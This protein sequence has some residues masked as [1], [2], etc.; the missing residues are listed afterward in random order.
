MRKQLSDEQLDSLL[1]QLVDEASASDETL[2]EIADSPA[3]W[4]SVQREIRRSDDVVV[5]PWPPIA[6]YL[7]WFFVTVP[8]AAAVIIA[9]IFMIGTWNNRS[10]NSLTSNQPP[11]ETNVAPS[12]TNAIPLRQ[13]APATVSSSNSVPTQRERS[14]AIP[15]VTK[16]KRSI[17]KNLMASRVKTRE[18]IKTDFISLTYAQQ[19]SSGQVLRVKVPSAMMVDLGV[20]PTVEK[21]TS[22][23]EAE[24]L[25]GDDGMTHAIRFI[26][27][28]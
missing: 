8:A 28:R 14:N 2:D 12:T 4:W 7:R 5:S 25:V 21:P 6:R 18:E 22:L 23:V 16:V 13:E 15:A 24:V 3:L 9:S 20:V 26:R 10:D 17:P 11:Q 1:R 19:P 27:G